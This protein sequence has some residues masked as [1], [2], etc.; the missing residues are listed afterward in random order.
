MTS[1]TGWVHAQKDPWGPQPYCWK[2]PNNISKCIILNENCHIRI[3][4]N[5]FTLRWRQ[6]GHDS[7][8]NH[9]PHHCLLNRLFR[10]RSKKAS[11]LCVT[12][13]CVGNSPGTGEFPAQMA[14][15]AENVSISWR[16][17][18]VKAAYCI[19]GVWK[20]TWHSMDGLFSNSA[21]T[22]WLTFHGLGSKVKVTASEKVKI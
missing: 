8:S 11:Q 6:N 2:F 3:W 10:R 16:H 19:N 21:H 1:L 13:L 9:Q 7:I 14:S 4:G 20:F 17:H 15:N 18:D 12:G 5:G 22:S